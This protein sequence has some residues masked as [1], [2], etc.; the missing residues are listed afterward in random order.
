M[1]EGR[2]MG[3][4]EGGEEGNIIGDFLRKADVD[5]FMWKDGGRVSCHVVLGRRK[6][7]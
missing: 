1:P 6:G 5:E 3:G 7:E 4:L 2:Q